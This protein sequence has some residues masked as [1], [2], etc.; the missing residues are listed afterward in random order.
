MQ[1]TA[2]I[3][4]PSQKQDK[5]G[6][7]EEGKP[8]AYMLVYSSEIGKRRLYLYFEFSAVF[9]CICFYALKSPGVYTGNHPISLALALAFPLTMIGRERSKGKGRNKAKAKGTGN[10]YS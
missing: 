7:T 3:A 10:I 4:N 6:R 9:C 1:N 2:S 8:N 5:N